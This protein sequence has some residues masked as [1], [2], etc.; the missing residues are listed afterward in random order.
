MVL[1]STVGTLRR[2]AHA[3]GVADLMYHVA[4][5]PL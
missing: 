3:E 4:D 1:F 2:I 5:L